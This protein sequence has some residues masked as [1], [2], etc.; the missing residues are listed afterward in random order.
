MFYDGFEFEREQEVIDFINS[1]IKRCRKCGNELHYKEKFYNTD[2][3]CN[4]CKGKRAFDEVDTESTAI[5]SKIKLVGVIPKTDDSSV[6][7]DT[8]S[9]KRTATEQEFLQ[10]YMQWQLNSEKALKVWQE[11]NALSLSTQKSLHKNLTKPKS[12]DERLSEIISNYDSEQGTNISQ[13]E[14]ISVVCKIVHRLGIT[15]TF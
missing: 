4:G 6:L 9:K 7:V 15:K 8:P 5:Q 11:K 13:D 1:K 2:K 14:L 10:K 12:T 3:L